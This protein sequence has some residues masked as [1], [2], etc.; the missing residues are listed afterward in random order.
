MIYVLCKHSAYGA[1]DN[2]VRAFRSQGI[3]SLLL[4]M[5]TE[6]Y[7]RIDYNNN[8]IGV[9]LDKKNLNY[10][11][12]KLKKKD[13][14]LF[15]ISTTSLEYF[16]NKFDK[17]IIQLFFNECPN[18]IPIF[19]TGTQYIRKN[20]YFNNFM[21]KNKINPRF[22]QPELL[23]LG[24]QNLQLLHPMQYDYINKEKNKDKI[25]VCHAPGLKRRDERKGTLIIE[26]GIKE[27]K[28]EIEFEY[29]CLIGLSINECLKEKAKSNIFI[30]QINLNVGGMGKNGLEAIALDCIT[31]SSITNFNKNYI[32]NEFYPKHPVIEIKNEKDV[33]NN[34]IEIIKN[35]EY[36]KE[37]YLKTKEW[38]KTISYENTVKYIMSKI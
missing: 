32:I 13:N 17:K 1:A 36:M 12:N 33:K 11:L 8:N 24:S 19:I 37:L 20:N 7:N 35:K 26:K 28:K 4:Y 23:Q 30:D 15:I 5:K 21:N 16:I 29:K 25:I 22:C 34:L 38:K 2:F 14:R 9:L 18:N 6:S 3:D 27:A 10:Y 31:M